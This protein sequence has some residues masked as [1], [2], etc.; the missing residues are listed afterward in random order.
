MYRNQETLG[1]IA[2]AGTV[3]VW[4]ATFISTKLLLVQFTAVEILMLRLVLALAA[5]TLV[6][7]RRMPRLKRWHELYFIAAGLTGLVLYFLFENIALGYGDASIV[8][9]IVASAPLFAGIFASIFLGER[10]SR[11][12]LYGFTVAILGICLI[13]LQGDSVHIDWRG[14]VLTI[15]AAASWGV[16]S[17]LTRKISDLGYPT[18]GATRNVF[19]YGFLLLL[20]VAAIDG[21]RFAA[22]RAAD[23]TAIGNL[24]FLGLGASA[25]CFLTWGFSVRILGPV[26]ACAYI[27]ASPVVTVCLAALILHERMNLRSVI[28]AVLVLA[29]LALS[30]GRLL[31]R[32]EAEHGTV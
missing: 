1:H 7:P 21:F 24:L 4:G 2:A 5:L 23:G 12:F 13:G 11:G 32:K 3:C 27:Y 18:L 22:V 28:G 14:V 9:V 8:G 10:L 6:Y 30:E 15:A 19:F 26:K 16:Y 29:G 20:P 17:I 31:P 25:L